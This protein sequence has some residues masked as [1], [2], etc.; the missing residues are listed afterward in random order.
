MSGPADITVDSL[1]GWLR[2]LAGVALFLMPGL[3]AADRFLAGTSLRLAW[4]PLFS[5]TILTLAAILL[6]FT[7]GLALRPVTTA[8]LALALALVIGRHR[9]QAWGRRCLVLLRRRGSR[10]HPA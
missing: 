10:R 1:A 3:A 8:V 5:F 2:L 6:D 7:I 4:A 9:L